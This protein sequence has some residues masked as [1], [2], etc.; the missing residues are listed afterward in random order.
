MVVVVVVVVVGVV[1][2]VESMCMLRVCAL[3]VLCEMH[4]RL[5]G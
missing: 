2:V 5:Q 4:G 1:V 3:R